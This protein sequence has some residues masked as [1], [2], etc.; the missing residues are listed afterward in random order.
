[1]LIINHTCHKYVLGPGAGRMVFIEKIM[2]KREYFNLLKNKFIL[3][4]EELKIQDGYHFQQA[5]EPSGAS[6][7][8]QM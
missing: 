1:M 2:N 3:N 5:S 6:A 4:P 8:V 7:N